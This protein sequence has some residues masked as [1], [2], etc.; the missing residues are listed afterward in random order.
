MEAAYIA[1]C[2]SYALRVIHILFTFPGVCAAFYPFSMYIPR[3][4]HLF[5]HTVFCTKRC[6]FGAI[7]V[8]FSPRFCPFCACSSMYTLLIVYAA[9]QRP[10][11][12]PGTEK[13]F[14]RPRAFW[15]LARVHKW[16]DF[17]SF[18]TGPKKSFPGPRFFQ[19]CACS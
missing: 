9:R 14:S 15:A 13:K 11:S 12:G 19:F 16:K 4:I 1:N 5:L 6:I 7:F 8:H 2:I 3:F 17:S 18:S 10:G